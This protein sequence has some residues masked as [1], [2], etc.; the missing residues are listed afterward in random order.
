MLTVD[1]P[2]ESVAVDRE[3]T[4][5]EEKVQSGLQG[6]YEA[7]KA[8]LE[9]RDRKLYKVRY[10]TFEDY[11]LNRW[12]MSRPQA[13][14]L[15]NATSTVELLS[16]IGDTPKAESQVRPLTP[17]E[18]EQQVEAWQAAQ[19]VGGNQPTAEVVSKA[20]KAVSSPKAGWEVGQTLTVSEG[21]YAGTQV[22]IEK[23][24]GV[25]C[26]AKTDDGVKP[27]LTTE[28]SEGPVAPAPTIPWTAQPTKA[29]RLQGLEA[30]N[31]LLEIRCKM[32]EAMLTRLIDAAE[33]YA[34]PELILEAKR[35]LV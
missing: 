28:L 33:D 34:E 22:E 13:Y 32:L 14:R 6:F 2:A 16:P 4:L 8:L 20:A 26:F 19:T 35:L 17:L 9:I 31:Q 11:C 1:I 18:P 12:Q 10:G 25:I 24:D 30:E 5:L 15:M 23:V 3:L 7:G 29:D 21:E 27:F